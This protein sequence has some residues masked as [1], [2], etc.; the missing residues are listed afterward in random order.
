MEEKNL[1]AAKFAVVL[2]ALGLVLAMVGPAGADTSGASLVNQA[3]AEATAGHPYQAD[4]AWSLAQ[5]DGPSVTATN[6]A[7]AD[8]HDCTGCVTEA[9]A[10][11][12]VIAS[13]TNIFTL[14]NNATSMNTNCETCTAVSVAEQ[15]T[16]GDTTQQLR[17]TPLGQLELAVV[18]IQLALYVHLVPPLQALPHILALANEVSTIL[19]QDVVEVPPKPTPAIPTPAVSPLATPAPSGPTITHYAQVSGP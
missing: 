14:T 11:Q 9:V 15:W 16:V 6:S 7:L 19:A 18:H 4:L 3:T 5:I 2:A 12:V 13:D 10:F 8:S 1:R 17:I